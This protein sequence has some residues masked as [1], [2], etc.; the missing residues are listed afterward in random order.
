MRECTEV[1]INNTLIEQYSVLMN[2][3]RPQQDAV[4][5]QSLERQI[6]ISALGQ[7][8]DRDSAD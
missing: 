2:L 3:P 8:E 1:S 7:Y 6:A 4:A 5:R